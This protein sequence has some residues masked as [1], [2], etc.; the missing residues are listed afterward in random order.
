MQS[1]KSTK[2]QGSAE[3]ERPEKGGSGEGEGARVRGMGGPRG[4]AFDAPERQDT[5]CCYLSVRV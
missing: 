1:D 3:G 2:S 5:S 4:M